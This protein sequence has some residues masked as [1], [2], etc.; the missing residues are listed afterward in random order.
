MTWKLFLDDIRDTVNVD[1]LDIPHKEIQWNIARS[2]DQAKKLV[3]EFNCFPAFISFDHDLGYDYIT[4]KP[5]ATGYDFAKWLVDMDQNKVFE[6]P[7]NFQFFVHSSN[8]VGK[9]NIEEYLRNYFEVR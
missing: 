1:K 7:D 2:V 6:F 3:K 9:R 5:D 4:G 8:P